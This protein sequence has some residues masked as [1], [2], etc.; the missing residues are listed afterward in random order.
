M[1][2]HVCPSEHRH[3]ENLTCYMGHRCRCA[4]C[5]QA[6]TDYQYWRRHQHAAG[7]PMPFG[8]VDATGMVRRMQA[9][10]CM[11][12]SFQ[13]TAKRAGLGRGRDIAAR[14]TVTRATAD[15]VAAAYEEM[16][17]TPPRPATREERIV[18]AKTKARAFREGWAPPLAW[19]DDDIDNPDARPAEWKEAA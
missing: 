19:D 12:W 16:W 14:A 11:G 17:A 5:R 6:N 18:V 13:T 8:H 15:A 1:H 9:L 2:E 10:A 3:G 7:R 4:D